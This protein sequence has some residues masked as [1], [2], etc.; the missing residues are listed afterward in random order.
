MNPGVEAIRAG[1]EA[2]IF[3]LQGEIDLP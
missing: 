2:I 1:A 3:A